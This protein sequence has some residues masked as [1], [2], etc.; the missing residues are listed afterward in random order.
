MTHALSATADTTAPKSA[1]D[2]RTEFVAVQGGSETTSAGTLL[3]AAYGLMW[4]A[5]FGFLLTT[6][7]RQRRLEAR[8]AALTKTVDEAV[9]RGAPSP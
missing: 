5:L 4:L 2:R 8:V 1:E 6:W 7:R 3:V 9:E